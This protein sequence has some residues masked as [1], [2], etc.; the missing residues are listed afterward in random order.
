MKLCKDCKWYEPAKTQNP[1]HAHCIRPNGGKADRCN[2]VSGT[3][4]VIYCNTE[5]LG[6]L[7]SSCG[8][9]GK[10]FVP[11]D[12]ILELKEAVDK[13]EKLSEFFPPS[14]TIEVKDKTFRYKGTWVEVRVAAGFW[15]KL[16]KCQDTLEADSITNRLNEVLAK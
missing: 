2:L 8:E 7:A 16:K 13:E 15:L 1:N 5:R 12:F 6:L 14:K 4:N 10:Y 3:Q 11:K 9:K